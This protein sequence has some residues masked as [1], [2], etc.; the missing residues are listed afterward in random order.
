VL[1]LLVK[2]SLFFP[3][4]LLMV[5]VNWTVDPARLFTRSAART[6]GGYEGEILGD[7][8]AGRPH[9][10]RGEFNQRLVVEEI[11]RAR[12]TI[13]VLVVGS[14]VGK[15]FH[16]ELFPGQSM[17]NGA[18]LNGDLEEAICVYELAWETG[19]RPKRVVLEMRGLSKIL[20]RRTDPLVMGFE[21]VFDRALKRLKVA[22]NADQRSVLANKTH[23]E[24]AAS[25]TV[26]HG[27]FYPYDNLISPRYLQ[28]SLG[29][30]FRSASREEIASRGLARDLYPEEQQHLL[31]RDGSMQWCQVL[32]DGR[33]DVLR[34]KPPGFDEL[35]K[36]RTVES[37]YDLL[38]T[39]M[40]EVLRS[41]SQMEI[42]LC[43]PIPWLFDAIRAEYQDAGKP[44][45][46]FEAEQTIR[47]LAQSHNVPVFG[48]FDPHRTALSGADY[49]DYTHIRRESIGRLLRPAERERVE[50]GASRN[51]LR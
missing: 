34:G 31:Y 40:L 42:V 44:A 41:G 26:D 35:E 28:M 30:L 20:G 8:L 45:P 2:L 10:V 1:R 6:S 21:P 33:P 32:L 13:D 19:K 48:S 7:L 37:R 14:S 17:V 43:P 46:A 51:D 22:E 3:L 4:V 23:K 36:G 18:I 27:L 38:E 47:A 39:F 15:P 5:A 49:V 11:I 16:A 50:H 12:P 29:V 25:F 24:L 9:R